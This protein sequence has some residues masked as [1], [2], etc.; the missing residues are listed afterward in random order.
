MRGFKKHSLTKR[1]VRV[2]KK[3]KKEDCVVY[4]M[5]WIKKERKKWQRNLGNAIMGS[6]WLAADVYNNR[7][8]KQNWC[9][10]LG[11]KF[12]LFMYHPVQS[13]HLNTV[14]FIIRSCVF[15]LSCQVF[16]FFSRA[17]MFVWMIIRL[18]ERHGFFIILINHFEIDILRHSSMCYLYICICIYINIYIQ[19]TYTF[20]EV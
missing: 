15:I 10:N 5:K 18:F 20:F 14:K 12:F 1:D 19:F 2:S 7:L 13:T 3:K 8:V 9:G 6:S 17:F 11:S 16:V 4:S